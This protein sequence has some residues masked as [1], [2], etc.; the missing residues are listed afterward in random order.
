MDNKDKARKEKR[1][2][3]A[4][5]EC[6]AFCL[7]AFF[8]YGFTNNGGCSSSGGSS[9]KTAR[10]NYCSGSGRVSGDKCPWCGGSGTT[11]DNY[12]NDILGD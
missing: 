7:V 5:W 10:C 6:L 9:G 3:I 1:A 12:F 8:F 2:K 4:C 11:Y